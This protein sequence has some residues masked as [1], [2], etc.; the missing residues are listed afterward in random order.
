VL[1]FFA[2]A[3]CIAVSAFPQVPPAL[4]RL[5]AISH[6]QFE[7]AVGRQIQRAYESLL[8]DPADAERAGTLGMILQA[9]GKYQLAGICYRYASAQAPKT[10]RWAYYL[11]NIEAWLGESDR[12][13]ATLERAIALERNYAPARVRLADLLF[14]LG[15][16]A[17]ALSLYREVITE[18]PDFPAAHLGLG[19]AL[20]ADGNLDGA[21]RSLARACELNQHDAQAQYA[22]AMAY[23]KKGDAEKARVHLERFARAK[24]RPQRS[25]D[26]LLDAVTSLYAGALTRF[27]AGSVFAQQGKLKE[28]AAEFEAALGVNPSLVVAHVNLIAM[29]ARL[30]L[31]DKAGQH[32]RAAVALDP[33]WVEA[34]YNWGLFLARQKRGVEAAAAFRKAVDLN[35]HYPD[36]HVQLGLL[37]EEAGRHAE[38]QRHYNLALESAPRHQ[39]ARYL[40]GVQLVRSGRFREAIDLLAGTLEPESARTPICMQALALAYA[41]AG[42]RERAIHYLNEARQRAVSS[43]MDQFAAQLDRD[44][45]RIKRE[46]LP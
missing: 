2:L 19:K 6:E 44:L 7:P 31:A 8:A 26:P 40:A 13:V 1:R 11:G 46:T 12:A 23:R 28:A 21:I 43:G 22:L 39:Q 38:A 35:P 5:E 42:D 18:K 36:A 27:A 29:Y 30:G 16:P 20:A 41:G 14:S 24:Q 32:F 9:Y 37:L 3:G 34:H 4:A 15:R 45:A 33:G 10:F 17:E 25:G